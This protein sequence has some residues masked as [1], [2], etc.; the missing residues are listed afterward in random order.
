L[1]VNKTDFYANLKLFSGST[2]LCIKRGKN[3]IRV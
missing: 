3:A 2:L 1:N